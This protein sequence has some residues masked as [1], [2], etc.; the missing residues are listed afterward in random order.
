MAMADIDT[1]EHR[2]ARGSM[3]KVN[4]TNREAASVAL[5]PGI[6][7]TKRPYKEQTTIVKKFCGAKSIPIP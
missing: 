2:A 6:E 3:K 1:M 7:P 4:G 5:N